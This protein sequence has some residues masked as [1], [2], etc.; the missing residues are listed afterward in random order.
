MGQG[1]AAGTAAALCAKQN[2]GT[3]DVPYGDLPKPWTRVALFRELRA[4]Q[5]A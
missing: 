5:P 1:Q 4:R 3:R 2:C